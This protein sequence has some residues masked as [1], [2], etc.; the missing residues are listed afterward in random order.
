MGKSSP[1]FTTT[2]GCMGTDR[3]DASSTPRARF[4]VLGAVK[5]VSLVLAIFSISV[6]AY[7]YWLGPGSH[8]VFQPVP[9]IFAFL[10]VLGLLIVG[11]CHLIAKS[12][13]QHAA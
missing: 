2:L 6:A 5:W 12:E 4:W 1:P 10:G 9:A 7:L 13:R 11:I 8:G 3:A